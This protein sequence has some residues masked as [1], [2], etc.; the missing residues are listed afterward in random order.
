L[1][2]NVHEL[3]YTANDTGDKMVNIA[4]LVKQVPDTNSKIQIAGDRV[5]LSSVKMDISPY[6]EFAVEN[7]LQHKESAGGTVTAITVGG[8]GADKVLKGVKALGVDNI[9]RL[10][11]DGYMDSNGLQSV[12]AEEISAGGFDVVYCGKAAADTGAGSTGPGLAEKLGWGSVSNATDIKFENGLTVSYPSEGGNAIVTVNLPAI[13][14]CDKGS[15]KVRKSNVKGIMMAKRAQV[16][17]KP[18]SPPNASV[19]I[20]SQIMPPAKPAGKQF[21]GGDSANTVAQ[22]LRDE[23]NII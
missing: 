20:V 7:A 18:I 12:L 9:I 17:V 6:D 3:N 8:A 21:E 16:E 2:T 13:V 1:N 22:L 10:D 14:S 19:T 4:V 11:Y 15:I 5:D 23:A